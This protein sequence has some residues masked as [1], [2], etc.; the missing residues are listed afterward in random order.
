MTDESF[1][2]HDASL[3]CVFQRFQQQPYQPLDSRDIRHATSQQNGFKVPFHVSRDTIASLYSAINHNCG[4]ETEETNGSSVRFYTRGL[5]ADEATP[6]AQQAISSNYA[7]FSSVSA[8][9]SGGGP[10]AGDGGD[11]RV[12]QIRQNERGGSGR[13]KICHYFLS[14]EGCRRGAACPYQHS[15]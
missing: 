6:H 1:L 14:K 7:D 13:S 4:V 9:P 15:K 10:P 8:L 2:M 11:W 5:A 12:R 3:M